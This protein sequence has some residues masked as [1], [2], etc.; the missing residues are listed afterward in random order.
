MDGLAMNWRIG[1]SLL[2]KAC[3]CPSAVGNHSANTIN[4]APVRITSPFPERD[5]LAEPV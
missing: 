4:I 3:A 1:D 5:Q 2:A